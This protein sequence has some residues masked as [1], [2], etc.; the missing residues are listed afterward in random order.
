LWIEAPRLTAPEIASLLESLERRLLRPEVRANPSQL[1]ALL[2]P[3]FQE[4]G[5][6]G[7]TYSR[8]EVLAEFAGGAPRYEVWAQDFEVA[9]LTHEVALVRFRTGHLMERG[10]LERCT[11]RSSVWQQKSVGEWLLR[12]HQGTPTDVFVRT[13]P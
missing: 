6:L 2:H 8:N 10:T 12:H 11:L 1:G 7:Q 13:A 3:E 4:I 5:R 9:E